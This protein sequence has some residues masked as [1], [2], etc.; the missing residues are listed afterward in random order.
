M[1]GSSLESLCHLLEQRIARGMP[2]CVVDLLEPVEVQQQNRT[3]AV[4]LMRR[5]QDLLERLRHLEA[6]GEAGKRIVA[7]QAGGLLL[8]PLLLGQV[9]ARSAK[10]NEVAEIVIDRAPADR[11]PPRFARY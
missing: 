3:G 5:R 1:A 9:R 2:H 8:A 10:P 6:V 11:P 4:E 7:S